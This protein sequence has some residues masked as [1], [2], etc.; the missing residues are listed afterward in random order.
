HVRG[1]GQPLIVLFTTGDAANRSEAMSEDEALA[2]SADIL[3]PVE[4]L[5][6][7]IA[8][9]VSPPVVT[10]WIANPF[11]RGAYSALMPGHRRHAPWWTGPVGICGDSFDDR[12][13]ASLAGAWRSARRLV[14]TM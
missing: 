6:G 3:A 2:Y 13:P 11:T 1:G 5:K 8:H 12:F 4:D 10:R 7:F 9:L 14:E